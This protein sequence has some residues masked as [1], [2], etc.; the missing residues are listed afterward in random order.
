MKDENDKVTIDT[1]GTGCEFARAGL[2]T[3]G[4]YQYVRTRPEDIVSG[5]RYKGTNTPDA[6]RDLWSTPREVVAYMEGRFGKYDL[7]A[8]A[9]EENK[10]CD[11][12]YSQETN[13]LKR[14]WGKNKHVWLNPPYS[15]PDVFVKKAIEQMEHGNQIDM[16]L[17]A[18]NSTAWFTEA[19]RNAAEIIWIEGDLWEDIDGTEFARS[20]RLAFISGATGKQVDGN[21]KGSVLFVIRQLKEGETQQ[22]HYVSIADICPSVK[23]KRAK[24][25]NI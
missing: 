2:V 1:F 20:G 25:R 5:R 21:N 12:F 6:V 18:D 15:R 7:D 16:L 24:A 9:S 13:C 14:W 4:H 22:T 10:V 11:K 23:N 3:G 19:R 17:P 8:A